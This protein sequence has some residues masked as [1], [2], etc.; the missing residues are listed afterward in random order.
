MINSRNVLTKR[1]SQSAAHA[2]NKPERHKTAFR[3]FMIQKWSC[4]VK[5]LKPVPVV[6]EYKP[7]CFLK[8]QEPQPRQA[9]SRNK[10]SRWRLSP[11]AHALSCWCRGSVWGSSRLHHAS[12]PDRRESEWQR[13][14]RDK[15]MGS[16]PVSLSQGQQQSHIHTVHKYVP[17]ISPRWVKMTRV[18]TT[19]THFTSK[20]N[21][22]AAV[23]LQS[24]ISRALFCRHVQG[25]LQEF[26]MTHTLWSD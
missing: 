21:Y 7:L 25:L 15:F 8:H 3:T 19:A 24:R 4:M 20:G 23:N 22:P 1:L 26:C 2:A 13:G 17:L 11:V 5:V 16:A 6:A 12:P 14:W 10:H 18:T 9:H